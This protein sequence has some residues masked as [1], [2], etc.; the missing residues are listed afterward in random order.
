MPQAEITRPQR[1]Y[2]GP[3]TFILTALLLLSFIDFSGC[4]LHTIQHGSSFAKKSLP[5]R[6]KRPRAP[7]HES[8]QQWI[9]VIWFTLYRSV[10]HFTWF[11][12][13]ALKLST[14]SP[15]HFDDAQPAHGASAISA[16]QSTPTQYA[17]HTDAPLLRHTTVRDSYD[18]SCC[19]QPCWFIQSRIMVDR[20]G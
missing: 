10:R 18:A 16:S 14:L 20:L 1:A 13:C 17:T 2:F 5:I 3:Q 15:T 6:Q 12:L 9:V 11:S 4:Y 8:D 7:E 19:C